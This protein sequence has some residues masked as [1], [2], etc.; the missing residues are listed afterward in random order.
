MSGEKGLR[1]KW[2]NFKFGK[3]VGWLFWL[4]AAGTVGKL[5]DP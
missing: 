5:G 2:C 4:R 1:L 3:E